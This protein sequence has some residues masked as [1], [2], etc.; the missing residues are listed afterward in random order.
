MAWCEDNRVDYVIGVAKNSR[1]VGKIGV[2]LAKARAEAVRHGRPAR[3]F[4]GSPSSSTP[5]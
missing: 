4:A 1:L 3:R 2:E 5:R